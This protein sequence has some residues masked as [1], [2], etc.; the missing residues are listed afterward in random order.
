M[1]LALP[2]PRND[3]GTASLAVQSR[4][5]P[6]NACGCMQ[7][8]RTAAVTLFAHVMYNILSV[9]RRKYP[10]VLA[11]TARYLDRRVTWSAPDPDAPASCTVGSGNLTTE[12][13]LS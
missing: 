2:L 1:A 6:G 9:S 8:R 3:V 11:M 7:R 12:H 4:P 13:P 10:K 5:L